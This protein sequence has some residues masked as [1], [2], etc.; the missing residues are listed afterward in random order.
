MGRKYGVFAAFVVLAAL[1]AAVSGY[2]RADSSTPTAQATPHAHT[3][4]TSTKAANL[5][6]ALNRLLGEHVTL[7]VN[8]TRR[9][10]D[11]DRDFAA[12][13][14]ALDRN[15]VELA[16]AIGSIYG[17]KARNQFLNGKLLW[18]DHIKFFVAYTVALKAK[19]EAGQRRAVGNLRGYIEA[20]SAFLSR[21]TGLPQAALRKSI[22]SHVNQLKG[23]LDAYAAGNFGFAYR[24]ERSAYAHM[25][26][27]GDALSTAIV[28]KFPRKFQS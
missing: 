9:G 26:M 18:R 20:F 3:V 28:K 6:V 27:T 4:V 11:G 24:L 25:G 10:Y 19:D 7:A 17:T 13:A 21:A 8:A 2:A 23:Q 12:A 15:S 5:R 16:N 14:A 1:V 22:T